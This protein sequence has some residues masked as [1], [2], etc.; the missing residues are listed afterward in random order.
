MKNLHRTS[1]P[2]ERASLVGS[3]PGHKVDEPDPL[4]GLIEIEAIAVHD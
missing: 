4:V 1:N 2:S 3:V